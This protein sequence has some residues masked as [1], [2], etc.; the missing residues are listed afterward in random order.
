MHEKDVPTP[1]PVDMTVLSE[2]ELNAELE[3]GYADMLEDRTK[4]AKKAFADI[5]KDYLRIPDGTVIPE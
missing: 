3:K 1:R 4:S 5:C 2:V